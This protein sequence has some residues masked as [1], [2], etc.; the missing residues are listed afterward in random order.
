MQKYHRSHPDPDGDYWT[1]RMNTDLDQTVDRI[2]EITT[3]ASM[4][5]VRKGF[6]LFNTAGDI[7]GMQV[8]QEPILETPP[9][10]KEEAQGDSFESSGF[11]LSFKMPDAM[12]L[13]PPYEVL[14][15]LMK[16]K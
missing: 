7:I 8:Y 3:S 2:K 5:V 11:N 14:V 10:E 15:K 4:G 6:L 9:S 12:G 16:K 13:F 1:V